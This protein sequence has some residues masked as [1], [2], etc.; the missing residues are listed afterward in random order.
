M[1]KC[2]AVLNDSKNYASARLGL[3]V[4][5]YRIKFFQRWQI[6]FLLKKHA[7]KSCFIVS[8]LVTNYEVEQSAVHLYLKCHLQI[9]FSLILEII[10]RKFPCKYSIWLSWRVYAKPAL[11]LDSF[12]TC[13]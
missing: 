1:Y 11:H 2:I 13:G 8:I 9:L 7:R 6:K 4:E 12:G 3:R 5:S 10:L